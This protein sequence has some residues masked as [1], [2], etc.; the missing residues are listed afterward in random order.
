M[1]LQP[2]AI[3]ANTLIPETSLLLSK[4]STTTTKVLVPLFLLFLLDSARNVEFF[5]F[6]CF[7]LNF[8]LQVKF[9][10]DPI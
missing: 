1:T 10:P 4:T 7:V 2:S 3:A 5:L 8:C 9:F 6:V